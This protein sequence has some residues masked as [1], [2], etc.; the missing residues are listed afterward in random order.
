MTVRCFKILAPL[1]SAGEP[2]FFL[3]NIDFLN[4]C[5]SVPSGEIMNIRENFDVL[6][7][8][9]FNTILRWLIRKG[10]K[11]QVAEEVSQDVWVVVWRDHHTLA[12]PDRFIG[13]VY[14]IARNIL[15]NF[16]KTAYNVWKRESDWVFSEQNSHSGSFEDDVL[17]G[18]VLEKG[19]AA[20]NSKYRS[21]VELWLMGYDPRDVKEDG[22]TPHGMDIRFSK[23]RKAVV[24]AC[25]KRRRLRAASSNLL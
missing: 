2:V 15:A 16:R 18:I 23:A 24:A 17:S 12:N 4:N 19:L 3:Y 14:G 22:A 9:H 20:V 7:R 5:D 11:R 21:Y 10:L 1:A 6:Y 13:W 25:G 8:T